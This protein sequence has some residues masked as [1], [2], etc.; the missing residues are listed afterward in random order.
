MYTNSFFLAFYIIE[1]YGSFQN[2]VREEAFQSTER[3]R[4]SSKIQ[5]KVNSI[6]GHS[7]LSWVLKEN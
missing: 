4:G 3:E 1:K 6:T 5:T 7:F 2:R